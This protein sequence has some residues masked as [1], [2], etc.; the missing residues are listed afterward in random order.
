MFV[1]SYT[2][3]GLGQSSVMVLTENQLNLMEKVANVIITFIHLA[4]I[5][6][7]IAVQ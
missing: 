4:K 1:H 5:N 2:S 3:T 6:I 7:S